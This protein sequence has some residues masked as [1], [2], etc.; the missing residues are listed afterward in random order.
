M[1]LKT[2]YK[3]F[4]FLKKIKKDPSILTH[5]VFRTLIDTYDIIDV[6]RDFKKGGVERGLV[7]EVIEIVRKLHP[8]NIIGW[9][10]CKKEYEKYFKIDNHIPS[11]ND[12]KNRL[13]GGE[14]FVTRI[15]N[16]SYYRDGNN[17]FKYSS[18][19]SWSNWVPRVNKVVEYKESTDSFTLLDSST[20]WIDNKSIQMFRY[21]T[22]E[23]ID[24]YLGMT[25]EVG[26]LET[27]VKELYKEIR[28]VEQEVS[29]LKQS[30]R[31]EE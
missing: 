26:K 23:E 5:R 21:S 18:M 12:L 20:S 24:E 16:E 3:N 4:K 27:Q 31:W 17:P 2:R 9:D 11:M 22:Q 8:D 10:L 19:S 29:E 25:N 28:Q 13:N 14:V 1:K 6:Y 15:S 30:N 7:Y